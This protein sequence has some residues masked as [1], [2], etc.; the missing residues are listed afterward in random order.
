MKVTVKVPAKALKQ[1]KKVEANYQ[2][3]TQFEWFVTRNLKVSIGHAH[4]EKPN[5]L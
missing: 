4:T 2:W 5:G 3:S 1:H